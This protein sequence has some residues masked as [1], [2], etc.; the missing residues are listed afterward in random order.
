GVAPN[1]AV[2]VLSEGN[3][4]AEIERK[5]KEYFLAG[6]ELAWIVDPFKRT[7]AVHTAPDR[8]RTLSEKGT[9]DGGSVLPG[10]TLAVRELFARLPKEFGRRRP[11]RGRKRE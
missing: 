10:F 4:P 2:E 9:L 1:L 3:T 6:V 8:L 7:V 5:L 11:R